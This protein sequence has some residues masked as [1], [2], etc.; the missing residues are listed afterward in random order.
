MEER[1]DFVREPVND[2]VP[3]TLYVAVVL[4]VEE[5]QGILR[6]L[7]HARTRLRSILRN[8]S[9]TVTENA[10]L[11]QQVRELDRLS[12][13]LYRYAAYETREKALKAA[14]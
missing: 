2:P 5:R 9:L 12:S 6:G 7:S 1:P 13:L 10:Q 3:P 4:T 11:Q 14:E 8:T